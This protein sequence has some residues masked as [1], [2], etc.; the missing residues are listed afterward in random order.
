MTRLLDIAVASKARRH[1]T[2][3]PASCH[4]RLR[5]GETVSGQERSP[6]YRRLRSPC[7]LARPACQ[8]LR[9]SYLAPEFRAVANEPPRI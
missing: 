1:A 4:H 9:L 2:V 3:V 8:R 6:A 7:G 5:T